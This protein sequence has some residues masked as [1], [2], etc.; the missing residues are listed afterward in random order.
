[1]PFVRRN[2]LGSIESLHR[3]RE[4]GA[5]EFLSDQNDEVRAFLGVS[6]EGDHEFGRLDAGFVRVIE[7]LID[8]LIVKNVIAITDLP[9]EAQNKLFARKNFRESAGRRSLRLFADSLP[10][11]EIVH[12]DFSDLR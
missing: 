3:Q 12:T 2:V 10:G 1:M 11:E 4:A 6:G 5:S 9:I 8:V 7:D